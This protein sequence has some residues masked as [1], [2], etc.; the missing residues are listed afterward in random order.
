PGRFAWSEL[1]SCWSSMLLRLCRSALRDGTLAIGGLRER[2]M[3]ML[4]AIRLAVVSAVTVLP[5]GT[6]AAQRCDGVHVAV[7]TNDR[8]LVP[9]GGERFKDC[10]D[11]PQM[12]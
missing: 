2:G 7:G 10:A 9:G 1:R 12:V 3:V 4:M 5:I 11:C 8:C 6:A